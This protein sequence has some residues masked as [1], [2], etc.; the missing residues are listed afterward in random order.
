MI[1][2]A[3]T[4]A[5]EDH[6]ES[7]LNS[8]FVSTT[9]GSRIYAGNN[10][11]R[12]LTGSWKNQSPFKTCKSFALEELHLL[13]LHKHGLRLECSCEAFR[14]LQRFCCHWLLMARE[15]SQGWDL[16][17]VP[18]MPPTDQK[19]RISERLSSIR[20]LSPY[21]QPPGL[22]IVRYHFSNILWRYAAAF[23]NLPTRVSQR[24]CD[25]TG[26]QQDVE[27]AEEGLPDRDAW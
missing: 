15:F 16:N 25:D 13:H 9:C 18:Q 4:F 2:R 27:N 7:H 1:W 14:G 24:L 11:Y 23:K 3:W 8:G 5:R 6:N 21:W 20:M 10:C 26:P 12:I 22:F 17:E 19:T